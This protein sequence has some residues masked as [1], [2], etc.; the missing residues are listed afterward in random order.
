MARDGEGGGLGLQE[1]LF[2]EGGCE[3]DLVGV[4]GGVVL[5]VVFLLLLLVLDLLLLELGVGGAVAHG[6]EHGGGAVVVVV[7]EAGVQFGGQGVLDIA[8]PAGV[9]HDQ[10]EGQ[11]L[12]RHH[13]LQLPNKHLNLLIHFRLRVLPDRLL[14]LQILNTPHKQPF[15]RRDLPLLIRRNL[16]VQFGNGNLRELTLNDIPV[17]VL[18]GGRRKHNLH[19]IR[20]QLPAKLNLRVFGAA[21]FTDEA[22]ENY[23]FEEG[24]VGEEHGGFAVFHAVGAEGLDNYGFVLGFELGEDDLGLF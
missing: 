9:V 8:I 11:L 16:K 20:A 21:L 18:R 4:L 12:P 14:R 6:L 22:N 1:A 19:T 7:V 10:G 24:D 13:L 15:D 23:L 17:K 2:A 3:V 5:R